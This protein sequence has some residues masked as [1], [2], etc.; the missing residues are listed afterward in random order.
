MTIF[1]K[2]K[3]KVVGGREAPPPTEDEIRAAVLGDFPPPAIHGAKREEYPPRMPGM[4]L[5]EIAAERSEFPPSPSGER[6]PTAMARRVE[7]RGLYEIMDRLAVIETQLATVRAQTETINE[8]I[9]SLEL[10]LRRQAPREYY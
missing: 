10:I 2:L 8:R 5:P 9:K 1:G 4:E 7:E 3:K 6:A